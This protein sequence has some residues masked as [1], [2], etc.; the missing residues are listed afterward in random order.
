MKKYTGSRSNNLTNV[1]QFKSLKRHGKKALG[2]K[3]FERFNELVQKLKNDSIVD[4]PK[5]VTVLGYHRRNDV[6]IIEIDG[7]IISYRG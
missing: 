6:L 1:A 2:K 7:A 4:D 5:N 3:S